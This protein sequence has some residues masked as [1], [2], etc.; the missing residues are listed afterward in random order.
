M[1]ILKSF[2]ALVIVLT[3]SSLFAET[4]TYTNLKV[5]YKV[6]DFRPG[7]WSR[8]TVKVRASNGQYY[9]IA[10]MFFEKGAVPTRTATYRSMLDSL[11]IG[12]TISR[13]KFVCPTSRYYF[14]LNDTSS[15][16]CDMTYL[17]L[18]E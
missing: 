18:R 16:L 17:Y 14:Q 12:K 7:A 6:H 13:V 4:F 5:V 15:T 11:E 9:T 1:K 8:T 2:L 10:G 3:S